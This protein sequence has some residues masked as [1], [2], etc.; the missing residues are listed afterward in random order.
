MTVSRH[1]EYFNLQGLGFCTARS[2]HEHECSTIFFDSFPRQIEHYFCSLYTFISDGVNE[3][4]CLRR[5]FSAF[6]W[7]CLP[8]GENDCLDFAR[9]IM[10]FRASEM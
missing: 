8:P 5:D 4:L 6:W 1:P 7:F 2:V 9:R 10:H 3:F